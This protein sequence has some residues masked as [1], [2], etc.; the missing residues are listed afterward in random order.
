[1]RNVL[2]IGCRIGWNVW[3]HLV[4][5]LQWV[6][7]THG[8]Y[9][10]TYSNGWDPWK[11][12]ENP[13]HTMLSKVCNTLRPTQH[14]PKLANWS[15]LLLYGNRCI[16]HRN[17]LWQLRTKQNSTNARKYQNLVP[18]S[19]PLHFVGI[20]ICWPISMTQNVNQ[21]IVFTTNSY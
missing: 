11:P 17:E 5:H 14:V 1:M 3:L 9:W 8:T 10:W 20:D 16:K 2:T 7:Y 15:S 4:I 6:L 12:V 21:Y 19:G 18:S 13:V